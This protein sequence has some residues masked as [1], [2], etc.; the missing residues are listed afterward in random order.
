MS[1]SCSRLPETMAMTTASLFAEDSPWPEETPTA[2]EP[3]P[4]GLPRLRPVERCQVEMRCASLDQLLPP[5][6]DAR[7]VWSYVEGVDIA[8]L[9]QG[10]KAVA[11]ESGPGAQ[12]P[13]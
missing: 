1:N 13:P 7:L 10:V 8:P 2:K 6:H 5:E 3:A 4:T 12:R 11:G 9:L